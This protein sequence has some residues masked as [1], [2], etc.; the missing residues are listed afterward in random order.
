MLCNKLVNYNSKFICLQINDHIYNFVKK[1][2]NVYEYTI[3]IILPLQ[4]YN[5][6]MLNLASVFYSPHLYLQLIDITGN[7][8]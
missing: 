7:L 3:F 4:I 2:S 8:Q 5:R 6:I 1:A